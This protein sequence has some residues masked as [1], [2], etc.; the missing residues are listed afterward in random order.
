MQGLL[1]MTTPLDLA[2]MVKHKDLSGWSK[3]TYAW[4]EISIAYTQFILRCHYIVNIQ[5]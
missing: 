5:P 2:E 3:V 1:S 4:L